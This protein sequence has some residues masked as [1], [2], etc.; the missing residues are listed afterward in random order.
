M[1]FIVIVISI[2]YLTLIISF[3]IG[4]D[5]VETI[6][7]RNN[8]PK[9]SFSIV[10]PFRNEAANLTALLNSISALN[11]PINL[12]EVLLINDASEDN[13]N[14]VIE[15][16]KQQNNPLNIV[17]LNNFRRTNSPKKDA[18]NTAIETAKFDWI[19]TTDAD[20]TVPTTWLQIFNQFIEEKKP[21]F[22]SAPVNFKKEN[23]FLFHFQNLNFLSL[24]GSTIGSFG[25]KKPI[26]CNGANLCYQ[27]AAFKKI[28]GFE[29]NA[30]I[31][32][33]D[34]I[35]LLEK[36]VENY[37]DETYFLKSETAIVTT[38]S[39]ENWNSF[40]NQQIRW[41]SKSTAYKNSFTKGVGITIFLMNLTVLLLLISAIFFSI[42]L[43]W[44]FITFI[45][46]AVMDFILIKK[47]SDFLKIT[48]SM[49]YFP[50]ISVL[51]PF[52]TVIIA[53]FSL[54]KNYE[55]KG[56]KFKK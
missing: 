34:D 13:S 20:C 40:F 18:I 54:F 3:I 10:I 41:T 50:I 23:S 37:P 6:K 52:F 29:G 4:F 14:S 31:A 30:T 51:Y 22:I 5:K 48:K 8:T 46:K 32:S 2:L 35:F 21:V 17:I 33:G 56:R 7:N 15:Q 24:I 53:S 12:F 16:F 43:K 26:L 1:I 45:T 25:V 44:L 39:E 38:N 42:Y 49:N 9:N 55:W 36:M 47:T 11:Y 27:I 28:N 19:V